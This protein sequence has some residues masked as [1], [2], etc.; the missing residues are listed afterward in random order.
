MEMI[1]RKT[2]HSTEC[3]ISNCT[4]H[5]CAD[6]INIWIILHEHATSTYANYILPVLKQNFKLLFDCFDVV[7][8]DQLE[9]K[10]V[11]AYWNGPC[12]ATELLGFRPR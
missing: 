11:T 6:R 4:V 12:G 10:E 3:V 2:E 9:G 7:A 5:K 1:G 8:L